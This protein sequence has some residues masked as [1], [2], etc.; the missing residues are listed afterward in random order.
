MHPVR[1]HTAQGSGPVNLR[2]SRREHRGR[3]GPGRLAPALAAAVLAA[4]GASGGAA[5]RGV[6]LTAMPLSFER[7]LGQAPGEV[8]YLAHGSKYAI[9]LSEKGAALAVGSEVIRLKVL[10]ARSAE[11]VAEQ[12][13]PGVVNYIIGND[14]AKWRTGVKTFAQVRYAG[15]YPG[16]DLLYY[17]TQGRLEYDFAVAPGASAAPIRLAFAG[18]N[19]MHV[20][21]QGNLELTGNGHEVVFERPVAYQMRDGRRAPVAARYELR[22]GTV[23]FQLGAYD[24][25]KQLI[26]DPVLSYFSYLGGSNYDVAGIAPPSGSSS[27]FSGQ[28][29]AI[30]SAG[31]LYVTGYT[32]STNFPTQSEFA[33]P[34]AKAN[35]AGG[36]SW[37]FVTKFSA[38]AKTLIFSTYLGG[39]GAN[40]RA[41]SIAVD[42]HGNAIVVGVAGSHDFPV[43]SAAYQ[44]VCNPVFSGPN[45]EVPNCD[46]GGFAAFVSKLSPAGALLYSTFLS[47]TNTNT[48][49][50]AVA[51]DPTGR[52]YVA[53]QTLPGSVVPAGT[54]GSP[55]AIPF[56]TT[57]GA[58]LVTPPYSTGVAGYQNVLSAQNDAF[59]SVFDPTLSTLVYSS[60]FGEPQVSNAGVGFRGASFTFGEAVTV[61]AAGNFYL[62]GTTED[63]SL[64]TTSGAYE[65]SASSC[66]TVTNNVLLNCPFVAKFSAVGSGTPSLIYGTYLG[67]TVIS[68]YGDLLTGI[69][70]DA[71]GDAY[72]T[73]FTNQATFPTTSGAYQTTCNQYGVNGNTNAQCAAAFIAKLNPSGTALLA[74]TYF[75]GYYGGANNVADSISSM[76][77][78]ALD[79]AGS[80]YIDGVAADGLPQVNSLGTS[81]GTGGVVSPFVAK[82]NS[83]LTTLSFSTLLSTGGQSQIVADGLALGTAGSIYMAGSVNSPPAS[84][85]TSGAFQSAYGGGSSDAFV[86]KIILQAPATTATAL[87]V[88]PA[89]ANTGAAVTFTATVTET[90]GTSVPT[91]TVKFMNG[92]NMLGSASLNGTGVATFSSSTLAAGSYS[93][94]AAYQGD[95]NNAASSSSAVAL[96]I[97]TPPPPAPTVTISVS[98]S[99]ITVGASATV[100]WSSTNAT[101]CTGSNA[102]SGAQATSGTLA[103]T[104]ASAGS[105]SY[106]LS[107]TGAGGTANGTATLTVNAA[108]GGGG[109]PPPASGGGGGGAVDPFTVLGLIGIAALGL[110]RRARRST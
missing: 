43:T 15:V 95:S 70:A 17:G 44:T 68:S 59:I 2:T 31:D 92:S 83:S 36:Q 85:A 57:A 12:P 91:G 45:V 81:N 89:S 102:W 3:C 11:P 79:A 78:I 9:G 10:G 101:G 72:V 51:V 28:T 46:A 105:L 56:P 99:T 80:V 25:S 21:A 14:P 50:F 74:S 32:N 20:D 76:G 1:D 90:S 62:A 61:D 109:T 64:P 94:T 97:T 34:P 54:G 24:H 8:E 40:D 66:G 33:P 37:A 39:T 47:G 53:G 104:P 93:V 23:R 4:L 42:S 88:V 26:I 65:A 13:L 69:A 110:T 86:A 52:A 41:A 29:A 7:N 63:G 96:S 38:D 35:P 58:V 16:V 75:G 73:G 55:Q 108:S 84:V 30:D 77:P 49:A 60:L 71:A 22:G 67:H 87:T 98:P 5:A 18:A 19:L 48:S 6:A 103:V 82:F 27:Y 100:T 106:A 107:C